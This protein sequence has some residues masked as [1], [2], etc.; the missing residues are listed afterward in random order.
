MS[1]I[2]VGRE[3]NKPS[4]AS[5][6]PPFAIKL[7]L[8]YRCWTK[9]TQQSRVAEVSWAL[10]KQHKSDQNIAVSMCTVAAL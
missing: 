7:H 10:F 6:A 3:E 1:S 5:D 9:P 8:D 4:T 2:Q